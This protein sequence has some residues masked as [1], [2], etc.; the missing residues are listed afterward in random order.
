M[1]PD[2]DLIERPMPRLNLCERSLRPPEALEVG[3]IDRACPGECATWMSKSGHQLRH[4]GEGSNQVVE[5]RSVHA[6]GRPGLSGHGTGPCD[7][8]RPVVPRANTEAGGRQSANRENEIGISSN[9][10]HRR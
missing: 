8:Q 6:L 7:C 2:I 9:N 10:G 3:R 5:Q 1:I 4:I